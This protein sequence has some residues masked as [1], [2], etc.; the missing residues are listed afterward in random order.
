V[1]REPIRVP[2]FSPTTPPPPPPP[3]PEPRPAQTPASPA[4]NPTQLDR[5]AG[6]RQLNVRV[7][8]PL[9]RRYQQL[10]RALDDDGFDTSMA[11]LVQALLH[12][13]PSSVAEAKVTI[14]AWRR[15]LDPDA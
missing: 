13:G 10:L 2:G 7:L 14:R 6:T 1:T 15:A 8:L 9:L 12:A 5:R 4:D 3:P 11:E